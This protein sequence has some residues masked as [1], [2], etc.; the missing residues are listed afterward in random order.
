MP[1]AGQ[2]M[3]IQRS[4]KDS[5]HTR[6]RPEWPGFYYQSLPAHTPHKHLDRSIR[7]TGIV[8]TV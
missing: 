5:N 6:L 1:I 4:P 2:R 8:L 3:S 7:S